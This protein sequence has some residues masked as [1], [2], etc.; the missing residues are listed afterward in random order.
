[1]Y[2]TVHILRDNQ[3]SIANR[4]AKR[5]YHVPNLDRA[6]QIVEV[7]SSSPRGLNRNEIAVATGCTPTMV[8]RIMM[9]FVD[10]GWVYRDEATGIYRLSRRLLDLAVAGTDECSLVATAWPDMCALRDETNITVQLGMITSEGAGVLLETAES[11]SPIRF[12]AEKGV[13]VTDLHAGAGWKSILAFLPA[14]E[15]ARR[16]KGLS[17]RRITDTTITSRAELEKE[18]E[19]VRTCGYAVDDS[20]IVEGLHCVAAP[21]FDRTGYPIGTLTLSAPAEQL[22]KKDFKRRAASVMVAAATVSAKLGWKG[23]DR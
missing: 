8:Y 21:I 10:A 12:V 15:C 13:R 7:L 11:R 17:Y 5:N 20:E 22:P 9:T 3:V 4:S 16:L 1:M 23:K 6:L 18:L 14:E 2:T 19:K